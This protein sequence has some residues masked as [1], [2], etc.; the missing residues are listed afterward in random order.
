[1][2]LA[3]YGP[4]FHLFGS[5]EGLEAAIEATLKE[6]E[7]EIVTTRLSRKNLGGHHRSQS[8]TEYRSLWPGLRVKLRKRS[9]L[10]RPGIM[11]L[12]KL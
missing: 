4:S 5:Q 1:M 11:L 7:D 3:G 8:V 10:E 6:F 9:Q 12:Q 2:A